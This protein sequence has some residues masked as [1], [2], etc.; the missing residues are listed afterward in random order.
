V[1]R[2][3]DLLERDEQLQRLEHAL[4]RAREGRGRLIAVAAEAGAGKT[5]LTER[6]VSG[7]AKDA[8]LY[9][10]ACE[11]LSTPEVLLPLRDIARASGEPLDFGADHIRAFESLLRL[12]S[13]DAKPAILIIE[14]VHWA[15]TATLD[16]IRFLARRIARVGAVVLI[17]YREEEVDTRSP[18]RH[19]LGEAPS[20]NVERL[21]L[22]PLS[23]AAVT[24]LAAKRGRRGEELFALTAGNAFLV[25][26][27]LAVEGDVPTDAVRDATLARASRLSESARAV[28]DAVSIFPRHAE[29]AVVADLVKGAIGAGLDHCVEKGMLSLEG[30]L[31]QFRHELARRA[32]E[33]SI[34]P[35]RRAALHQRVIDVL[36][37]RSDARASQIAHHAERAGDIAALLEFAHRAAEQAARAGAP[38]EAAAHFATMLRHRDS[39]SSVLLLEVLEQHAQQAYLMGDP[40]IAMISM[41]EAAELR[42]RA[43]DILGLGRDLT[44]LTRFAWMCGRRA[45]AERFV[46]EAIAVLETAPPGPELAWAYS[47][48]S[49]LDMLDWRMDRAVAWGERALDLATQLNEKEIIIHA[50][51]N[52]G[53]AKAD[54]VHG[55]ELEKSFDLAVA[56][57]Y[58]DHVERA[59]CNLACMYYWRRDYRSALKYIDRGV[60]YAVA[61]ELRHWEAYLRGWRSMVLL[62]Q[63]DWTAAEDEA[64]EICRRTNAADMYRFPALIALARLRVRRGDPD[65]DIPLAAARHFAAGVAELQRSIYVA[66]IVAEKAWL[67][68]STEDD[69][70]KR[71]LIEVQAWAKE[72]N[73]SWIIEDAALW[74]SLLG[75]RAPGLDAPDESVGEISKLSSPFREHCAGRWQE[76]AEGWRALGRPYEEA[77]ALSGGD[78]AGQRAALEILDRLGAVPAAARLRRQMRAGGSRA[79]PR[80]PIAM[81]RANAAGLTRRQVQVLGLLGEAL[82]NAEIAA[83]L[84]I[85]AKTAEHHVS[86]IMARLEVFS[87]QEAAAAG[88]DRGLLAE[89][90]K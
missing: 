4:T 84:C 35:G 66:I 71:M 80:G 13:R 56:G 89:L 77:L 17:T 22:A 37:R 88:R 41:T 31:V 87:R 86:A 38:R 54:G 81:T 25:T 20:G 7:H 75:D 48:Q 67:V 47:H 40:D 65:A 11:N 82:S 32:V 62:D 79:I 26:E 29:T 45:D 9:W 76:A 5:A 90:I 34:A 49:Q 28:L 42:R 74:L 14:D 44:R 72:R 6:F 70:A 43:K 53:A 27:A 46:A 15:D 50:L 85:S 59:S 1:G 52:I 39:L 60:S 83:R 23:L 69:E 63:G 55:V 21:T 73:T 61:L 12:L 36:M 3:I 30:G 78:D 18:V 24:R 10:G 58:H 2:A 64:L 68:M 16:L 8:R 19:L 51:G 57:K 33:A